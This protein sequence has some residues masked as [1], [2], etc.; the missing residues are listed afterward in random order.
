MNFTFPRFRPSKARGLRPTIRPPIATP[1]PCLV[2]GLPVEPVFRPRIEDCT[3]HDNLPVVPTGS[4][5]RYS[6]LRGHLIEIG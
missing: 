3:D 1:N 6:C 2:C 4:P 5:Q